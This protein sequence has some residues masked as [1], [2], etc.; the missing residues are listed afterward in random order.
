MLSWPNLVDAKLAQMRLH[1]TQ[2]CFAVSSNMS[3]SVGSNRCFHCTWYAFMYCTVPMIK[4]NCSG[5]LLK[6][7]R[8]R[9]TT[10]CSHYH[11]DGINLNALPYTTVPLWAQRALDEMGKNARK[12]EIKVVRKVFAPWQSC[13]LCVCVCV[14]PPFMM[15]SVLLLFLLEKL[16][17]SI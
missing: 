3:V 15:A 10:N 16:S 4:C 13:F 14:S 11:F 5:T 9:W 17:W 2:L 6:W 1:D 8:Q 7:R 12:K